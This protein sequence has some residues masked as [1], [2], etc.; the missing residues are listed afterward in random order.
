M[1]Y[2]QQWQDYG[3]RGRIYRLAQIVFVLAPAVGLPLAALRFSA[4]LFYV[5]LFA[6]AG[7]G[8]A[9]NLYG[10][11]RSFWKCPR[12]PKPFFAV[13]HGAAQRHP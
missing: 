13:R 8:F 9:L 2:H 10:Y 7:A 12:C 3:K 4:A 11:Y 6:V 1:S 5:Y